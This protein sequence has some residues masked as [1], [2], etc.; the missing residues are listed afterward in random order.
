MSPDDRI[1]IDSLLWQGAADDGAWWHRFAAL[2]IIA[3][4]PVVFAILFFAQP[5]TYGKLHVQGRSW[6]GPLI[7]AKWC[8][9]LFESPNLIWVFYGVNGLSAS[10]PPANTLL[11]AW[12]GIHYF[13]RCI[14]YPLSMS[15]TSKHPI[16]TAVLAFLYCS[17]NGYLQVQGLCQYNNRNVYSK[18]TLLRIDSFQFV[19]GCLLMLAGFFLVIVSDQ[20]LLQLKRISGTYQIPSGG[21]FH[22]VSS[23]HYLGEILEWCGF[24]IAC[25]GSLESL[26][27]AI[28][29][30]ANLFPRAL[31][32]HQWYRQKF[33][34]YPRD[35]KAI[36]PFWW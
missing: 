9:M 16:G 35:R 15:T 25:G 7:S 18:S 1:T 24:C 2:S 26:S 12:F 28:W 23:P 10:L 34:D 11:L 5:S 3:A 33:E 21:G 29:T 4:S 30:I 6:L 36:I 19:C 20:T 13:R 14:L 27:F 32:Q 8:W 31:S 22:Y 17:I